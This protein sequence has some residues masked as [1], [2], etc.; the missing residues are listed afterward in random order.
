MRVLFTRVL[1]AYITLFFIGQPL[2][3]AQESK[4]DIFRPNTRSFRVESNNPIQMKSDGDDALSRLQDGDSE[5]YTIH[6]LGEVGRPGTIKIR[7]SDRVSDALRYAGNILPNGSQRRVELRREGQTRVIDLVSYQYRGDL[8]QNP[9]L[10]ENDVIFIPVKAGEIQVEGPVNRPG[11]YEM[12]RSMSVA[13]AVRLAGGFAS[14]RALEEPVKVIRYEGTERHVVP[15]ENNEKALKSFRL[16]KGD[17]VVVPHIMTVGKKFDYKPNRIPGDHMFLPTTDDNV[18]VVGAVIAPGPYGFQ[19]NFSVR[20][21][22]NLAGPNENAKVGRLE[23]IRQNGQRLLAKSDTVINPGDTIL[24]KQKYW[25]PEVVVGWL[26]TFVGL[27]TS[28]LLIYN[29]VT[30]P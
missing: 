26:T 15:V 19:P 10:M 29:Q 6:V 9:Y 24:V 28:S 18:Y 20:Q 30:S 27:T 7:P 5:R 17:I 21:Y 13:E 1:S 12:S 11:Y 23:I 14:G 2:G 25:K 22:A 16:K 4:R 8:N 3:W